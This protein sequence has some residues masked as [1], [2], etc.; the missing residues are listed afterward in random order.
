MKKAWLVLELGFAI[1]ALLLVSLFCAYAWPDKE[2]GLSGWV[3]AF[4]SI[5]AI[6]GAFYIG[7]H[8]ADIQLAVASKAR[9]DLLQDRHSTVKSVVDR[10]YQKCLNIE[11][12]VQKEG[13]LG[14]LAFV[15][16]YH[17]ADFSNAIQLLDA[18]PIFDLGSGQL[19][20]GLLSLRAAM[21]SIQGWMDV[22][23]KKVTNTLADDLSITDE[24]LREFLRRALYRAKA[25]YHQTIEITG[26]PARTNPQYLFS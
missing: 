25:A 26:G 24:D 17:D 16:T 7:K 1:A 4:G 20:E 15:M 11:P 23:R 10:A 21:H 13:D 2:F 22:H 5:A 14:N 19:V 18:A 9:Q 8:Q 3:Q 6:I 12:E